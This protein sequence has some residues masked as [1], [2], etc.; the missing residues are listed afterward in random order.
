MTNEIPPLGYGVQLRELGGKTYR[1]AFPTWNADEVDADATRQMEE[2]AKRQKVFR[3]ANADGTHQILLHSGDPMA[4]WLKYL[5]SVKDVNLT[6]FKSLEDSLACG[7]I[8]IK[9]WHAKMFDCIRVSYLTLAAY[10]AAGEQS[11]QWI[12][13]CAHRLEAPHLK[14]LAGMRDRLMSGEL[15]VGSRQFKDYLPRLARIENTD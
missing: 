14:A 6:R 12:Y 15:K 13:E 2:A 11:E 5:K 3:Y 10:K 7:E 9:Q 4:D 8:T 1:Q